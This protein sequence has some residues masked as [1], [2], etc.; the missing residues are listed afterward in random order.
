LHS[1]HDKGMPKRPLSAYNIFFSTERQLLLGEDLA[2]AHVITDQ[3]RRKHRKTHGKIGFAEMAKVVG[4][5]WKKL[6]TATKQGF[7]EQANR[8]KERYFE[9]LEVWKKAQEEEDRTEEPTETNES[10]GDEPIIRQ[11]RLR[12]DES[13]AER[14]IQAA[15]PVEARLPQRRA[16]P[17]ALPQPETAHFPTILQREEDYT[18][19]P[20]FHSRNAYFPAPN[21]SLPA[22]FGS[23]DPLPTMRGRASLPGNLPSHYGGSSLYA[24]AQG[25]ASLS[26]G[27]PDA[28]RVPPRAH[29]PQLDDGSWPEVA[30]AGIG[31]G[32]FYS[33]ARHF[34][35][36]R[37]LEMEGMYRMHLAEAAL[38]REQ[39]TQRGDTGMA[40]D[41]RRQQ[42]GAYPDRM[43][44]QASRTSN[45]P[46]DM[47]DTSTA[48]DHLRQQP[49]AYPGLMQMQ[50]RRASD[51]PGGM[52]DMDRG[53]AHMTDM[54]IIERAQAARRADMMALQRVFD[55]ERV[56][57]QEE[58]LR[59][60]RGL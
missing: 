11:V 15:S 22:N 59:K 26:G 27:P 13:Q 52:I 19:E 10:M 37:V 7:Q 53:Q 47:M 6:D 60:R 20:R 38:L 40:S 51:T 14:G 49:G 21:A 3:S 25:R 33:Q 56:M 9:N 58:E 43:Q 48:L 35:N 34:E 39:L 29:N 24:R 55:N 32:P 41:H 28:Y 44:M 17:R 31:G 12:D 54:L 57:R 36:E 18:N 46:G 8:E 45:A 42:P 50:A 30:S 2:S 5:R 1:S 23:N 4:Q 16:L